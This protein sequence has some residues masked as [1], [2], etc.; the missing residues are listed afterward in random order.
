MRFIEI[1]N[2]KFDGL[3]HDLRSN[4]VRL[5]KLEHRFDQVDQKLDQLSDTVQTMSG[6]I[7]SMVVKF[8]EHEEQ[9]KT[10]GSRVAVLEADTN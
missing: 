7:R 6:Q 5:D 10:I 1:A 9:F 8:G 3:S 4:S 2:Q